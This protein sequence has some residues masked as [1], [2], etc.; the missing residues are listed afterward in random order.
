VFPKHRSR[1]MFIAFRSAFPLSTL[2][3]SPKQ[4]K[5]PWRH[6]GPDG[7]P[8][9]MPLELCFCVLRKDWNV[10]SSFPCSLYVPG[11]GWVVML[12]T[13]ARLTLWE[14][15]NKKSSY[16]RSSVVLRTPEHSRTDQ[17]RCVVSHLQPAIGVVSL[18]VE[19]YVRGANS[20]W[21]AA[22][23]EQSILSDRCCYVPVYGV[24]LNYESKTDD[25]FIFR[26]S[27]C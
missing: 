17:I 4:H 18:L 26:F 5:A 3:T 16:F 1:G 6:L 19:A 27:K 11:K 24:P 15:K 20:A 7:L 10:S 14:M 25:F 12:T 2:F 23:G 13:L 8:I 21:L 22:A 9:T